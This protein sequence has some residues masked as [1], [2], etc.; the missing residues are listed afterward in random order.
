MY[1]HCDMNV[2]PFAAKQSEG[3]GAVVRLI[4]PRWQGTIG[5]TGLGSLLLSKSK[6]SSLCSPSSLCL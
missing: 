3:R 5:Q 4:H 1:K 6:D 2:I